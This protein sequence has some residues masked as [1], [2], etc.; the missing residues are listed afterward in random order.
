MA[1]SSRRP[2]GATLT[3]SEDGS[4]Q[5]QLWFAAVA[6]SPDGTLSGDPSFAPVYLP[7]QNSALPEPVDG[8]VASAAPS[9]GPSMPKG[10][11][12]PQWVVK[13]VPIT[14]VIVK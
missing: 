1:F 6:V 8:G 3:G 4:T 2:Y 9:S 11:H 10:N 13:Y 14:P 7:Q 5:P 12:I